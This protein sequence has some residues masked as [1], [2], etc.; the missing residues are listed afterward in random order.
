MKDNHTDGNRHFSGFEFV[1]L[2]LSLVG[3]VW[4]LFE[5]LLIIFWCMFF[6][7]SDGFVHSIYRAPAVLVL[8]TSDQL[9]TTMTRLSS[10]GGAERG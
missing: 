5:S 3:D 6:V 8:P 10:L 7:H 2:I 9:H 1:G 4:S